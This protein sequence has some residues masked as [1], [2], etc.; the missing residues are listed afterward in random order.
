MCDQNI[1]EQESER[2]YGF[3]EERFRLVLDRIREIAGTKEITDPITG[4]KEE[5]S[6]E[7]KK[8]AVWRGE[9][10]GAVS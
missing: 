2:E 5:L 6:D 4:T 10:F 9:A 3:E 8:T 7:K 1:S